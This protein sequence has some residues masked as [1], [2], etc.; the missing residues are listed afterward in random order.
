[1]EFYTNYGFDT[2]HTLAAD[3]PEAERIR[4][5]VASKQGKWRSGS[6]SYAPGVIVRVNSV[7]LNFGRRLLIAEFRNEFG[8]PVQFIAPATAEEFAE[9]AAMKGDPS[10]R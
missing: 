3:S 9:I 4:Q 5:V 2:E 10:Q 8:Y 6:A 1:M 7:K